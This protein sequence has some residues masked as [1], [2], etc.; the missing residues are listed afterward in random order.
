MKKIFACALIAFAA[1]FA[2]SAQTYAG[3]Y[4]TEALDS[5]ADIGTQVIEV[6]DV[7]Q[8]QHPS[9]SQVKMELEWTPVT[10]VVRLYYTCMASSFDRGE[11]MN[12][13]IAVY[14]NFAVENKYK[15]YTYQSKD[16]VRYYKDER[17][18]RMAEYCSH[19]TFTR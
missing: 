17:G 15:H 11:A 9:A 13:A 18:I 8:E 14:E 10:G 19:V 6:E 5:Y 16:R 4:D 1:V 12:T 3:N 2:V 7:Y